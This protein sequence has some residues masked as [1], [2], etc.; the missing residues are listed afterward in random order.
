MTSVFI[1]N[2][3]IYQ[4]TKANENIGK[5][6]AEVLYDPKTD[7]SLSYF[8]NKLKAALSLDK[9]CEAA[10]IKRYTVEI[11]TRS[12]ESSALF[13]N[14]RIIA[15][16]SD[17]SWAIAVPLLLKRERELIGKNLIFVF[18]SKIVFFLLLP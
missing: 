11:A 2:C 18:N 10:K 7:S 3:G 14:G 4:D 1:A 8:T 12:F 15:V 16:D 13:K 6:T 9:K 5:W 17:E